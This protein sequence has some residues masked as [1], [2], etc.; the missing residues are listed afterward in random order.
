MALWIYSYIVLYIYIVILIT[1]NKGLVGF[2]VDYGMVSECCVETMRNHADMIQS[3]RPI[4]IT[5]MRSCTISQVFFLRSSVWLRQ[6][7]TGREGAGERALYIYY[8]WICS[9]L[10]QSTGANKTGQSLTEANKEAFVFLPLQFCPLHAVI[11]LYVLSVC[12]YSSLLSTAILRVICRGD[13]G[14][15]VEPPV[16][17]PVCMV[18]PA[19]P[20]RRVAHCL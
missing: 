6:S 1:W 16:R 10:F 3:V 9:R 17:A 5:F 7:C 8:S 2:F 15:T 18:R 20:I 13:M 4:Y 14:T 11:C 12:L 19:V